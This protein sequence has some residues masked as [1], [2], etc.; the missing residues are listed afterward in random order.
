MILNKYKILKKSINYKK[1]NKKNTFKYYKIIII[2]IFYFILYFLIQIKIFKKSKPISSAYIYNLKI[3]H[4]KEAFGIDIIGNTFSFLSNEKG[5]F[6][7][8]ILLD[9]KI[10]QSKIINLDDCISFTFKKPLKY[11]K[12]YKYVVEGSETRNE[13][14]FETAIQLKAPFIKPKNAK[15]F[16]PIFVKDFN[17]NLNKEIINS[18]RL[19]I[20]GLGL[21][22]AYINNNKVGNAYLTPGYND[23]DYYLRYQTYNITQLLKDNNNIIEI[24]MGDGWYKGRFGMLGQQNIFGHEYKLCL[25]IVIE[26]KNKT[27]INIISDESWK[28]KRSKEIFNNIYDG[29]IVNYALPDKPLEDV[30]IDREEK[31]N[32]IPD[33]GLLIVQKDTLYPVLYESPGG[34]KILDFQQNMVGFVRFKG[35][36]KKSKK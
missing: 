5:P 19:Y 26:F 15:I 10:I 22:Q 32:L 11:N 34:E 3:N 12:K 13:L 29:E 6:K 18:A 21:Y 16:S 9:N 1:K 20:T 36:L 23:Y 14:E 30:I 4:L 27:I 24:H 17:L 28:V 35:F 7:T 2:F 25:H 8:Y 31:Y 33:F